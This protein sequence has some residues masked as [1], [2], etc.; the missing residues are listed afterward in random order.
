MLTGTSIN[1]Y[2]VVHEREREMCN[3][4]A[5]DRTLIRRV[6][7]ADVLRADNKNVYSKKTDKIILA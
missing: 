3:Q 4:S 7:S 1:I 2:H 6:E 5:E